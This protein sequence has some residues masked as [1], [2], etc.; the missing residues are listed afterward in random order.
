MPSWPVTLS[1]RRCGQALTL[2]DLVRTVAIAIAG[3]LV[4]GVGLVF[5]TRLAQ[6][7]GE[8]GSESGAHQP[9]HGNGRSGDATP[10]GAPDRSPAVVKARS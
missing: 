7:R 10:T 6:V 1:A 3:N 2:G 8:P 5:G 4:G 9:R